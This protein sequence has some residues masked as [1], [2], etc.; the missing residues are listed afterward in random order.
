MGLVSS[1]LT[2]FFAD[3]SSSP[4]LSRFA[5]VEPVSPPLDADVDA[6]NEKLLAAAVT[7][8]AV[9]CSAALAVAS[10]EVPEA[11]AAEVPT[12][13]E[14]N[15]KPDAGADAGAAAGA[16]GAAAGATAGAPAPEPNVN[17]V[18]F[19]DT[20][21]LADGL[22]SAGSLDD[23]AP[24]VNDAA[25]F[26]ASALAA[27]AA[28]KVKP[29]GLAA[30]GVAEVVEVVAVEGEEEDAAPKLKLV[31]PPA[32]GVGVGASLLA[33]EAPN[34]KP[35]APAG[36]EAAGVEVDAAAVD[37]EVEVEGEAAAAPKVNPP[38]P[39]GLGASLLAAGAAPNVKPPVPTTPV[40]GAG[41][42]A[43]PPAAGKGEPNTGGPVALTTAGLGAAA[44][45]DP[46]GLGVSHERHLAALFG[47][48]T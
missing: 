15:V 4:D 48:F 36:F 14:P 39:A 5:L 46:S 20:A 37:D 3:G 47:F 33:A 35:A 2:H 12:P 6:P 22:S 16:A 40:T 1:S 38:A 28:P 44:G 10:A 41:L 34:V 21:G 25:G 9:D 42:F 32:V 31:P 24:K 7:A 27:G 18:A 23:P 13:P 29:A 11:A 17:G 45:A 30:E 19:T 43:A 8:G 26:G